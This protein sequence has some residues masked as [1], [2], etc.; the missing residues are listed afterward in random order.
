MQNIQRPLPFVLASTNTGAMIVNHLDRNENAYGAYGVGYQYLQTASFDALEVSNVI[1]LLKLRRKYFKEGVFALDCGANIGAHT[2][3]WA[4]A[5][6]NWGGG[7]A[8]EAQERIYYAL[9]GNLALNNCFNFRALNVALGCPKKEGEFLNIPRLDY[10]KASSFGSLELKFNEKREFIG[11]EINQED[12][13]QKVPL[14]SIDSLNLE[15]IDL[16][17]LDVERMEMEVL[18]GGAKSIER[19]HPILLIEIIKSNQKEI[20]EFLQNLGYE[21]FAMGINIL[22]IHKQD[23]CIKDIKWN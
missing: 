9:A 18:E 3:P 7:I 12:N 15:R 17:K 16:I 21:I 5:T 1:E 2:I 10:T 14:I 6:T 22:A 13:T 11:Q 19:F 23:P 4:I 8:F 20:Q